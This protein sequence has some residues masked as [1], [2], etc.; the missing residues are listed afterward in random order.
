MRKDKKMSKKLIALLFV[1][2]SLM[3]TPVA[4]IAEPMLMENGGEVG[5]TVEEEGESSGPRRERG[6]C[7]QVYSRAWCNAHGY[8]NNRPVGASVITQLNQKEKNC[9]LSW[10]GSEAAAI[11]SGFVSLNGMGA[12]VGTA[13][14]SYQLWVCLR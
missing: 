8:A 1:V 2:C 9:L 6:T 11:A 4:A 13:A 5:Y 14:A 3:S 10:Y 12:L 7:S